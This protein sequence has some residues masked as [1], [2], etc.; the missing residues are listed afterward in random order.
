MMTMIYSSERNQK[1][2]V[3]INVNMQRQRIDFY[4]VSKLFLMKEKGPALW[5]QM[6]RLLIVAWV[7]Y[8]VII[9]MIFLTSFT[10]GDWTIYSIYIIIVSNLVFSLITN[11]SRNVINICL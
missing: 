6:T 9:P 3:K 11:V 8:H 10:N 4:Q 7:V 1:K 5:S 2:L